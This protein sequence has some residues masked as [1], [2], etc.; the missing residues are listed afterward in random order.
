LPSFQFTVLLAIKGRVGHGRLP[1]VS[2]LFA[3]VLGVN[4]VR[5]LLASAGSLSSLPA[6]NQ[7][8]LTGNRF[9]FR[10]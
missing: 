7:H 3:A 5:H 2:S 4:P 9:F 10:R 6:R 8:V 1:P